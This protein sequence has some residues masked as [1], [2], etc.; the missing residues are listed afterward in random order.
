MSLFVKRYP[1]PQR[2]QTALANYTWLS[3]LD[4]GVTFP[5]LVSATESRLVFNTVNGDTPGP[6]HLPQLANAVGHLHRAAAPRLASSSADP[7]QQAFLSGIKDFP[8][9]RREALRHSGGKSEL[10]S[11]TISQ[12]LP[13]AASQPCTFYK[14]SNLRNF[15]LTGDAVVVVVD[16]DDLTLAPYGYDLAKLIVSSAM[17]HGQLTVLAISETLSAYNAAV[18]WEACTLRRLALWAELNWLLTAKYLGRNG[19][20]HPWP[21]LRPWTNPLH[22]GGSEWQ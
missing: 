17:T 21:Q 4:S 9:S 12:I 16:F 20:T 13:F 15:I 3:S 14:D 5:K 6:V 2:A 18:G 19:Y 8:E 1:S 10:C 22:A 11:E 7:K